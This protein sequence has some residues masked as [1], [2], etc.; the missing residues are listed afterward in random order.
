[1]QVWDYNPHRQINKHITVEFYVASPM[2][3]DDELTIKNPQPTSEYSGTHRL[4]LEIEEEK[5]IL[6]LVY[7]HR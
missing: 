4:V 6:P 7:M 3:K 5:T 1:M 2:L